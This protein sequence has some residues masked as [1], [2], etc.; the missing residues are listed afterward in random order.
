MSNEEII[1]KASEEGK[2]SNWG[3]GNEYEVL[4]CWQNMT[5]PQNF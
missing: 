4:A 5:F 1:R 3:L 2:I